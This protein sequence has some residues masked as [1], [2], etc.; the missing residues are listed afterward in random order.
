M[1]ICTYGSPRRGC[2]HWQWEDLCILW[3][4]PS[5][6]PLL[7]GLNR[8]C[9][10][11]PHFLTRWVS[12]LL[13]LALVSWAFTRVGVHRLPLRLPNLSVFLIHSSSLAIEFYSCFFLMIDVSAPIGRP[14]LTH[15]LFAFPGW[16]LAPAPDVVVP[17]AEKGC[18]FQ[19]R[20][21]YPNT[22]Q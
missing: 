7:H 13:G 10:M 14:S 4:I 17:E 1:A 2:R 20:S 8:R 5:I 18:C 12:R 16:G 21:M 22:E 3:S 19:E 11:P 15:F 9:P 6:H